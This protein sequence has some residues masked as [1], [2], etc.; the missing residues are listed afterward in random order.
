MT[1]YNCNETDH[2]RKTQCQLTG[3]WVTDTEISR[4]ADSSQ[5][6][7]V[8]DSKEKSQEPVRNAA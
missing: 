3:H 7:D 6:K 1:R 2:W 4:D 5:D 8:D